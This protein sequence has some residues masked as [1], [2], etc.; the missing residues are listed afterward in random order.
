MDCR[1]RSSQVHTT[2]F[3]FVLKFLTFRFLLI[4]CYN[5]WPQTAIHHSV[6]LAFWRPKAGEC[7]RCS[8]DTTEGLGER[9][10]KLHLGRKSLFPG[11]ACHP[12]FFFPIRN[13]YRN[14]MKLDEP[15]LGLCLELLGTTLGHFMASLKL[16]MGHVEAIYGNCLYW[17]FWNYIF[18]WKLILCGCALDPCLILKISKLCWSTHSH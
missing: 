16:I 14:S 10:E 7:W 3:L 4:I 13:V 1:Y 18:L 9:C 5:A 12:N 15:F 6:D 8:G 11:V 2:N 17:K